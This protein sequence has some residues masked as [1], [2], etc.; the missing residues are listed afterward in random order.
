MSAL[1]W[2]AALGG[3]ATAWFLFPSPG[4]SAELSVERGGRRRPGALGSGSASSVVAAMGVAVVLVG[5]VG[6]RM[7]RAV[8]LA[9][10]VAGSA[11]GVAHL[12]RR[13]RARVAAARAAEHVLA[14]CEQIGADL[15]AGQSP[16]A[17]L[18]S[19]AATW[20]EL[21]EA[22]GTVDLGGDPVRAL[23]TAAEVPGQEGLRAVA[24]GFALAEQVGA[25]LV[26]V[27]DRIVHGLRAARE[28]A[29]LVEGELAS[30][31]ST[32]RLVAALPFGLLL[33]GRGTGGDPL[34]FLLTTP[35]G[36]ACLA[37]GLILAG[38]GVGW[39]D[40]LADRAARSAR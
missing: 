1:A 5:L 8:P 3:A 13:R 25:P 40:A 32:A 22:A 4:G 11:L 16:A 37:G 7:P 30:A 21:A 24:A 26:P 38:V 27:L 31:R 23:R 19:A 34:A 12:V 9:A 36:L 18:R 35:P 6:A 33:L 2:V 28:T 29:H 17:A 20:P 39:I 10:I 14:A 15:A